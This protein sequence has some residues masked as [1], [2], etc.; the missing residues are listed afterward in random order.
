MEKN[1]K[2]NMDIYTYLNYFAVYLKPTQHC[3]ST[4]FQFKKK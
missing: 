3:K 4:L 1:M 2:M